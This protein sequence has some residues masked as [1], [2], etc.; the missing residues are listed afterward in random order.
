MPALTP[1]ELA[2]A[3]ECLDCGIPDG[4]KLSVI[5]Y[6]LSQIA[7]VP[8]DPTTLVA[9]ATCLD[10]CIPQGMKPAV[11][12]DL[13]NTIQAAG[14]T[15]GCALSTSGDPQGVLVSTCTPAIAVDPA[16]QAIYLFTGIAGTN[17]GWA[18]KV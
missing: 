13:L 1:S 17:N 9:S 10:K 6:L 16:T 14:S 15:T 18:L 8:A 2:A 4:M 5:I 12:I 7:D 11:I 3:S